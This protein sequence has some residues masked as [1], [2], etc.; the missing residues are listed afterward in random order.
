M[1]LK[2]MRRIC[3][4]YFFSKSLKV[5]TSINLINTS[6]EIVIC[7]FRLKGFKDTQL[8]DQIH[9]LPLISSPSAFPGFKEWNKFK[10][11][12]SLTAEKASSTNKDEKFNF[13]ISPEIVSLFS[14]LYLLM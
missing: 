7:L 4:P 11:F 8:E 5:Y 13:K 6:H 10:T 12:L 3:F 1:K 2:A 14:S 9:P